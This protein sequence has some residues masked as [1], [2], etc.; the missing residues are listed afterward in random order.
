M[1]M[2]ILERLRTVAVGPNPGLTET[3]ATAK[4]AIAEIE[5]LQ[6]GC[7]EQARFHLR[8]E[9][10]YRGMLE[11]IGLMFGDKAFI[12]DDGSK[13]TDVLIAKIPELVLEK[14]L[15]GAFV[16][17][18]AKIEDKTVYV[19]FPL[20]GRE[21]QTFIGQAIANYYGW[22]V[23]RLMERAYV[24]M[25]LPE[26]NPDTLKRKKPTI[27]ELDA[28][29]NSEEKLDIC[30]QPDGSVIALEKPCE[31]PVGLPVGMR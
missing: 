16:H 31:P 7:T 23:K 14:V 13:S 8:N 30:I 6:E 25:V 22:Q 17:E 29:L 9:L 2:D 28:I 24:A 26:W 4:A 19:V 10:Y 1:T 27:E 18:W 3:V 20:V 15:S 5:R 11:E 21:G 12:C